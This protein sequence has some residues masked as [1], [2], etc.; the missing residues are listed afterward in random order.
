MPS[1]SFGGTRQ[2]SSPGKPLLSPHGSGSFEH[3]LMNEGWWPHAGSIPAVL[4]PIAG[5]SVCPIAGPIGVVA[6][7]IA[8]VVETGV[9]TVGVVVG[10]AVVVEPEPVDVAAGFPV[11]AAAVIAGIVEVDDEGPTA[12]G[13][14]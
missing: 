7:P 1:P 10:D 14:A 4:A 5:L 9:V 6:V 13:G 11:P 2:Y 12:G 8:G 3:G